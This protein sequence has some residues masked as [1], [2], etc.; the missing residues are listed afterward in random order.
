MRLYLSLDILSDVLDSHEKLQAAL[1]SSRASFSNS[2]LPLL[3]HHLSQTS[4]P[5]QVYDNATTKSAAP[6]D[7]S[8]SNSDKN[9]SFPLLD[10]IFYL[11]VLAHSR[12]SKYQLLES[13]FSTINDSSHSHLDIFQNSFLICQQSTFSILTRFLVPQ[14]C[15]NGQIVEHFAKF[16]S[17]ASYLIHDQL[18]TLVKSLS[19]DHDG[20]NVIGIGVD[21][22]D[23]CQHSRKLKYNVD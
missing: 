23:A 1:N 17:S 12:I 7:S 22:M 20:N 3:D 14:N 6:L 10:E 11:A 13:F 21:A 8:T 5:P 19:P 4:P 9:V 2:A 15:D 16:S 18:V